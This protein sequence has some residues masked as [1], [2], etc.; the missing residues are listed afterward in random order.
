MTKHWTLILTGCFALIWCVH[1]AQ[2][3]SITFDEANTFFAFVVGDGPWSP[4]SNNHVLNSILIRLFVKLFGVS[5]LS[6]R[7]PALLGGALYIFAAY[8]ICTLLACELALTW[9]LFVCFVYNP[10]V[11]DY[12]VAARGYGLAIGFLSLSLY[13]IA[14]ML[15]AWDGASERKILKT[16]VAAS[17]AGALSFCANFSFA[18]VNGAL[19]AVL[20]VWAG[21]RWRKKGLLA[22][23]GLA[24]ACILPGILV[25][26]VLT[27]PMLAKF[28]RSELFWGA[29]SLSEMWSY[30]YH[31]S[32][33]ALDSALVNHGITGALQKL[34]PSIVVGAAGTALLYLVFLF[35]GRGLRDCIRSPRLRV[36]ASV[37]AMLGVTLLAHWL[38]F[39]LLKIPW[40][41]DRTSLFIVPLLT[42]IV[43]CIFSTI[44][45]NLMERTLRWLGSGILFIA[46]TYFVGSL[47]DSYFQEWKFYGADV[48]AAFP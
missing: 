4:N 14:R 44:P 19:I 39:R 24:L 30:I 15:F 34:A 26:L 33:P 46:A 8:R 23:A 37:S 9:P 5:Q 10:F 21:T 36:V 29:H 28:P 41:L 11:M 27:G 13:L 1:R 32:F 35:L 38:Q 22:S 40:P 45:V 16:A 7:A 3:Q 6:V 43:G 25:A 48:K 18:Y 47:R 2:A 20:F 31:A 17:V 12:L 42:I